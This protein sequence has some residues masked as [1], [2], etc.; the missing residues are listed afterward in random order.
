MYEKIRNIT[1][2]IRY[3]FGI[4]S[5][6]EPE[7]AIVLGSGLGALA[8]RVEGAKVLRY[9]DID[10][11]P[12]SSVAGHLSRFVYGRLGGKRVIIM[13]GRVHYYE[14]YSMADVVLGVRVMCALGVKTL[15]TTNAAGC[16]HSEW[17]VGDL[18]VID[19][20][21]NLIP[22]PLIGPNLNMFGER[23]VDMNEAYS[24]N[25]R[26]LAHK[27]ASELGLQLRN[28]VYLASTG[29]TYETPAEYRFFRT[30]GADACGMSTVGEV[31]VARH[32]R[33]NVLGFSLMSNNALNPVAN[34][35]SHKEV[36]AAS[37]DGSNKF[38]NLVV[39]CLQE[40]P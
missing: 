36:L 6:E 13:Q 11:F 1:S 19:D 10:S 12:L 37:A 8:D 33:V 30:I 20:H 40:L 14:G 29:P 21:I 16:L 38:I 18:M 35:T 25:L 27:V 23:F 2:L 26:D 17:N 7:V 15:I 34:A 24:K 39:K 22:N 9:G 32:H 4:V 3:K 5:G 28:G 31:I